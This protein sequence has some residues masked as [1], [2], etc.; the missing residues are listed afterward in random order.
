MTFDEQVLLAWDD[1]ALLTEDKSDGRYSDD[2]QNHGWGSGPGGLEPR[3]PVNL[4][5][6]GAVVVAALPIFGDR[7]DKNA[8]NYDKD[9]HGQ[10][11][12]KH[13]Q[14]GLVSRYRT[15][16]FKDRLRPVERAAAEQQRT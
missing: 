6:Y 4:I 14:L 11:E 3:D 1:P 12:D 9:Q 8:G 5:G 13:K 10:P 16:R 7:V 15:R 2:D